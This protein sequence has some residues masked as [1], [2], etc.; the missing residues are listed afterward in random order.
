MEK[1]EIKIP[2]NE[3]KKYIQAFFDLDNVFTKNYQ[4][5]ESKTTMIKES[6]YLINKKYFDDIKE[7]LSY[8]LF[9]IYM[10]EMNIFEQKIKE[11]Y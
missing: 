6:G 7:K 4:K 11:K 5:I 9:K 1:L 8:S 3:F 2:K 10:K